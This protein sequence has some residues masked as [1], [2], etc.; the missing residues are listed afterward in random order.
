MKLQLCSLEFWRSLAHPSPAP[1]SL[2][3]L[4]PC[5][6]EYPLQPPNRRGGEEGG[7]RR[8]ILPGRLARAGITRGSK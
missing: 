5:Q 1:A 2:P 7:P 8:R 3:A 4:L 6:L